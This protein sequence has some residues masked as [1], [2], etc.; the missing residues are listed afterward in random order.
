MSNSKSADVYSLGRSIISK[1]RSIVW[2]AWFASV[3]L[4]VTSVSL[5]I[6]F[7]CSGSWT[8]SRRYL[9]GQRVFL[10]PEYVELGVVQ[11]SSQLPI[12]FNVRNAGLS[13]IEIM[14]VQ[15]TCGCLQL[16]NEMPMRIDA[17]EDGELELLLLAPNTSKEFGVQFCVLTSRLDLRSHYV[18]IIGDT[19]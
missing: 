6:G 18:R 5:F 7:A 10:T 12:R 2:L 17:F 3:L 4:L 16:Q 11:K 19:R 15:S 8:N 1:K 13:A 9:G 14:G